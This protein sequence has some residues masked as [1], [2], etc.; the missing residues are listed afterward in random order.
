MTVFG[1]YLV[2]AM[3]FRLIGATIILGAIAGFVGLSKGAFL[4]TLAGQIVHGVLSIACFILVGAAFWRFGWKIG[5]LDLLLVIIA[6]N[7]GL[8]LHRVRLPGQ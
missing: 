5:L 8:S 7:V 4:R 2:R 6:S 1:E 3:L